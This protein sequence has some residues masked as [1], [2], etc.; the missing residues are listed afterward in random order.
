[1]SSCLQRSATSLIK[2][3]LLA[4]C[5]YLQL[6][7][8][9]FLSPCFRIGTIF[10]NLATTLSSGPAVDDPIF[11]LLG[12]FWPVLEKLFRSEHMENGSLCV[13]ACR[14]CSQAI[15]SSDI[16]ASIC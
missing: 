15:H 3:C 1:M 11:A 5:I 2:I 12:V 4:K 10:N 16:G 13:A 8:L 6:I 14:A 7:L 9:R